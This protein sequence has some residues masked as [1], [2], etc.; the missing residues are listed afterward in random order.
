MV[1]ELLLALNVQETVKSNALNVKE[2]V[3]LNVLNVKEKAKLVVLF[4]VGVVG[5]VIQVL[6]ITEELVLFVKDM[7]QSRAIHAENV[8]ISAALRVKMVLM[9]VED[10]KAKE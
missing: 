1:R 3:K 9:Y 4:G 10:V 7:A 5:Q 6:A 8:V 2:V